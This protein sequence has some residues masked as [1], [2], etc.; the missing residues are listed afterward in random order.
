MGKAKEQTE[1]GALLLLTGVELFWTIRFIAWGRPV[2][3]LYPKLLIAIILTSTVHFVE[4]SFSQEK[5]IW[6][7]SRICVSSLRR[8]HAN[9]L[10][11]VPIL[12]DGFRRSSV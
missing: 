3:A 11:I 2:T 9:L 8:D 12:T 6:N 7:A 5:K 4:N 10:C 1:M